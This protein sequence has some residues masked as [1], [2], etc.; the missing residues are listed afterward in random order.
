V[1][2]CRATL[3]VVAVEIPLSS[4]DSAMLAA[5]G[6]IECHRNSVVR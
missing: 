2:R 1:A 5:F 3:S 6:P 4:S